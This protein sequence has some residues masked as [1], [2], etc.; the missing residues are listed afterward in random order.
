MISRRTFRVFIVLAAL[1]FVGVL[2]TQ[3]IWMNKAYSQKKEEFNRQL[4]LALQEVVRDVLKFNNTR[5]MPPNP[6]S[7]LTENG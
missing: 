7:Q 6:V 2:L 4:T 3:I 1:S 5:T